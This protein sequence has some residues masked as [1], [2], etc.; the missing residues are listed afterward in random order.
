MRERTGRVAVLLP[1]LPA[2]SHEVIAFYR[3]KHEGGEGARRN[4]ARM[5][6]VAFSLFSTLYC[7]LGRF[8]II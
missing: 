8:S 7:V 5:K 1:L 6:L 3:I 4:V 2:F